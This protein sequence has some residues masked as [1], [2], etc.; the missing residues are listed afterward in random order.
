VQD[1]ATPH[2]VPAA[3]WAQ[4]WFIAQAPVLPQALLVGAH[5]PCG[6]AAPA[7][8]KVQA[9]TLPFTLQDWQSP[10]AVAVVLQQTPST[11]RPTPH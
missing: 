7:P 11:H 10:Q 9:P 6:S 4:V 5:M 8:T 3:T 2:E 1:A